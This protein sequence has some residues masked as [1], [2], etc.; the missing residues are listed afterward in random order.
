MQITVTTTV[1]APLAEVWFDTLTGLPEPRKEDAKRNPGKGGD[2]LTNDEFENGI[3][4]VEFRLP[5][6]GNN[7]IALRTCQLRLLFRSCSLASRALLLGPS[8]WLCPNL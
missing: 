2:L 7:G 3:I 4:R 8:A 5:V 6:A 1:R